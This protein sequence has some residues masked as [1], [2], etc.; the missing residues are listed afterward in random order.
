M[1]D[2]SKEMTKAR[3]AL[4]DKITSLFNGKELTWAKGWQ[5]EG[6]V[7]APVSMARGAHYRGVNNLILWFTAIERG[8]KDNRWATFKQI[9]KNG[10][11]FKKDENGNSLGKGAGVP[12]EMFRY[13]DKLTKKDLDFEEFK[14]LT[15][16]EQR[17]YWKNNVRRTIINHT[18][19][20]ADIIEGV[21]TQEKKHITEEERN[22]KAEKVIRAWDEKQCRIIHDGGDRAFYRPSTDEIHLPQKT[23]FASLEDYYGTTLHEIGHATGHPSRLNR[24]LEGGFGSAKYAKEELRAELASVFMQQDIGLPVSEFHTKNH[25]AY[26]QHWAKAI[27]KEPA[28]LFDAIDDAS[29]ITKYVIDNAAEL[30]NKFAAAAETENELETEK[31]SASPAISP[32]L[33]YMLGAETSFPQYQPETFAEQTANID[34]P[35]IRAMLGED[36]NE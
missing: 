5:A 26:L 19:F 32:Q 2:K 35:S 17:E 12:I 30:E 18:V 9:E 14:K 11:S 6:I 23:D 13:Y 33:A 24:D 29:E 16:E 22:E 21:P 8:Y 7:Q 20:N 34:S 27:S 1:G 4:L 28:V 15:L 36:V 31:A 10:W 3:Q 25:V